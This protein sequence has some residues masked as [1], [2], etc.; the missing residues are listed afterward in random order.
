M[1]IL[2]PRITVDEK[3]GL[4][5]QIPAVRSRHV[6]A[7]FGIWERELRIYIVRVAERDTFEYPRSI[8]H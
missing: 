8:T 7:R 1:E 2:E 5:P 4:G 6:H 3:S